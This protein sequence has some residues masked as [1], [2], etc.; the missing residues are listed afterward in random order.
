MPHQKD[1]SDDGGEQGNAAAKD[2]SMTETTSDPRRSVTVPVSP[3]EAFR[4]YT[5]CAAEWLPPEHTFLTNPQ[6]I[7]MEPRAGGRFYER[8]ADGTE[9]S[10]GTITEWAPPGRLAV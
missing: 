1:R 6:S 3:A 8:A 4:I 9:I 7:T 2:P 10:R 5:Q